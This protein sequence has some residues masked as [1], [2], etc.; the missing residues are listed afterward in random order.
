[1]I[2]VAKYAKK[3]E[4]IR[5]SG[6]FV[7]PSQD[8]VDGRMLVIKNEFFKHI[9]INKMF[10][11]RLLLSECLN[12]L[13]LGVQVYFTHRF[14]GNQFYT[15]G[16]DFIHDDFEGKMD[17]LDI[18]FPKVTKCD[19]FKY[20][21]SGT[22]QRHDALCIMALN[23]IN[24]KIFVVLWFWYLILIAVTTFSILWRLITIL[25]YSRYVVHGNKVQNKMTI[26]GHFI[27]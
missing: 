22:I 7:I 14:L 1:M 12:A 17:A 5:L 8:T 15:L 16:L 10:A 3:K 2:A 20:G 11:Y 4:D 26:Y 19:F 18:V 21:A 23:V 13:N 6:N 27:I 25:L 9:R 24:E